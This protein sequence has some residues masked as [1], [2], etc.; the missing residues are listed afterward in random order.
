MLIHP[1]AKFN[2]KRRPSQDA[3]RPMGASIDDKARKETLSSGM[4]HG[5]SPQKNAS[6]NSQNPGDHFNR[7]SV[8]IASFPCS[9]G[10]ARYAHWSARLCFVSLVACQNS[11][12][13]PD[14]GFYP[15][16]SCSFASSTCS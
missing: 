2:C 10:A 5:S 1:A 4:L 13:A 7:R 3:V 6:R 9:H 12:R 11:C 8:D 15:R 16:R 14:L